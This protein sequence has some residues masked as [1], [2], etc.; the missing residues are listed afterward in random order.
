MWELVKS[1]TGGNEGEEIMTKNKSFGIRF[2][3]ATMMAL[4]VAVTGCS[5]DPP[6]QV[7]GGSGGDG[8]MGGGGTGGDGGIGGATP[9]PV[10][11]SATPSCAGGSAQCNEVDNVVFAT[12][13]QD[14]ALE[15]TPA[16]ATIWYT[17]DGNL[18]LVEGAGG[19]GGAGLVVSDS[20]QEYDGTP[21]SLSENTVLRFAAEGA[22]GA[23]SEES[24]EGYVKAVGTTQEQW[25]VSGHGAITEEPWRHWDEEGG[26]GA[27]PR[28]L[29]C[30]KCHTAGGFLEYVATGMNTTEQPL[31]AGLAC[32]ACHEGN[33]FPNIY[34]ADDGGGNAAYPELEPVVFPSGDSATFDN[35]SNICMTCHQG[36]ESTVS[37]NQDI[38]DC[39]ADPDQACDADCTPEAGAGGAGG[40]SGCDG[41]GFVNIH[42]Y[43]AAATLFGTDVR[44][45]YEYVTETYAGQ[46]TFTGTPHPGAG[47]DDCLG[48]H[49]RRSPPDTP[50]HVFLPE[51]SA[52]SGCH[53]GGPEFK[54]LGQG[55]SDDYADIQTLLPELLTAVQDYTE[56]TL[57]SRVVYDADSY[58]YWFDSDGNRY[59]FDAPSLK[60]AYNYQTGSKDPGNY[61]H[62]ATYTKQFL[63]DSIEDL[64]GT[65]SVT[66][67]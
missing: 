25:A 58:P 24:L 21:L 64:G 63:I 42:Y 37:V 66:R 16:D 15:A 28:E 19:A 20:A 38:A 49:M 54:D 39:V 59:R 61:I 27:I 46:N 44:G 7:T 5:D 13:T 6:Q 60:G 36:R 10:T 55:V 43:A 2:V 22:D 17:T 32:N 4:T 52:C 53:G 50:N 12:D 51:V 41:L 62:N 34:G 23:L 3:L 35:A 57:G 56:T 67:P 26:V 47:L 31:P 65:P 40:A 9:V 45:A 29:A 48:C 14:V 1:V 33:S 18:V 30:A 11:V 8:G